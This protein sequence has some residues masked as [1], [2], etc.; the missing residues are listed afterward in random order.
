MIAINDLAVILNSCLRLS[1][2]NLLLRLKVSYSYLY[3]I[4]LSSLSYL[5]VPVARKTPAIAPNIPDSIVSIY[6]ESAGMLS[7]S[8][9]FLVQKSNLRDIDGIVATSQFC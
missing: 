5:T 8:I 9:G 7:S 4:N 6:D 3:I 2:K 1:L